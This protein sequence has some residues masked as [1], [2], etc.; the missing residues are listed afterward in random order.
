MPIVL[1]VEETAEIKHKCNKDNSRSL[2]IKYKNGSWD[3]SPD[4]AFIGD[5]YVH[6]SVSL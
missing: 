1:N 4:F 3:D 2:R 5:Y 6:H